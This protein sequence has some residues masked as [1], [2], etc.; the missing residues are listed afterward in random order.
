MFN[1]KSTFK[2]SLVLLVWIWLFPVH[3]SA[4][5]PDTWQF[6]V[7][8]LWMD[9]KGFDEHSGDIVRQSV[10][11]TDPSPQVSIIDDRTRTP[12]RTN[13]EAGNTFRGEFMYR[14]KSW[15][16]GATGWFFSASDSVTGRVTSGD[17]MTTPNSTELSTNTISMWRETLNPVTNELES[18]GQS[19]VDYHVQGDLNT[20]T[21]DA[22]GFWSLAENNESRINLT[23]GAKV[24]RV[25]T[26]QAQGFSER[27]FIFDYF[28]A[29]SISPAG[30]FNNQIE[31]ESQAKTHFRG[32]GPLLG[33]QAQTKWLG[34]EIHASVTQSL[35]IGV[36]QQEGVF[37]DTDAITFAFSSTGPFIPCP[38]TLAAAGCLPIQSRISFSDKPRVYVPVTEAR[39]KLE[40][41]VIKHV[42]IG[43]NAFV[44][45]WANCPVPPTF[46]ITHAFATGSASPGLDWESQ[47]RTLVYAGAVLSSACDF[48]AV[49]FC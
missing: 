20:Y 24:G 37:R 35:L 34:V 16:I 44:S 7:Q 6:E 38:V 47:Q 30:H 41:Q 15:G 21:F 49:E 19:P 2:H 31:L 11:Q 22:F 33:L 8:Q 32:L 40:A 25:T 45:V 1:V 39:L 18:S 23:A 17:L 10:V 48:E 14:R 3:V 36:A 27:A 43:G 28:P 29:T 9:V 42:A 13:M 46:T 4:Q 5:S 12:I 26:N